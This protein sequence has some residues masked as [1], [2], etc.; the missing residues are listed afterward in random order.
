MKLPIWF[1]ISIAVAVT[2]LGLA[3]AW[4]LLRPGGPPLVSAAFSL[5]TIT[6]NAD[7][8]T[9]VARLTYTLRRAAN[10]SICFTDAQGT[11]FDFRRDKPTLAGDTQVDFSGVVDSYSLPGESFSFEVEA[12]VLQNGVYTWTVEATDADGQ[13]NMISGPLSIAEADTALPELNHLTVSPQTFTPNQDGLDDRA[14]FNVDLSKDIDEAGQ[15]LYLIGP[16]GSQLPIAES[17]QSVLKPGQRGTH[18]YDYDG[19]IDLGQIPPP[20]GKYRVRAEATDRVGQR[21]AVETTLTLANRGLP[22]A[23][24]AQGQ[25]LFSSQV[26][27]LGDTLSFTLTV[28]NYGE[29]PIRTTGPF[30]GYVYESMSQNSAVTGFYQEAGAFRVG[31]MCDTCETDFPWRW[32]IGTPEMLTVIPDS[33]G[34]RQY[35]LMPGQRS[36]ITGGIV[37]DEIVSSRNPQDFWAGLIHEQ[38]RVL[39]NR[40]DPQ[41]VLI[42]GRRER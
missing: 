29:T 11:R 6:P 19:G 28:E 14:T 2:A 32:A 1:T 25:V 5:D 42:E 30:S 13:R 41:S 10:V 4:M 7:G 36:V 12:R 24:I 31:L 21:T 33:F 40:S 27:A 20:N 9:D 15:R 8:Q 22:L 3:A 38:V 37:L 18:T 26:V 35:Y 39:N 17:Q 16:D 34:R 23:Q